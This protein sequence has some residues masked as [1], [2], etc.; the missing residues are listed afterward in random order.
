[1]INYLIV[2]WWK[3]GESCEGGAKAD[4]SLIQA[5]AFDNVLTLIIGRYRINLNDAEDVCHRKEKE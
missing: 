1:M 4:F 5:D 3:L 2:S